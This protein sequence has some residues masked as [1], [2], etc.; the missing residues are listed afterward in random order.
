MK[1]NH[2]SFRDNKDFGDNNFRNTTPLEK[3]DAPVVKKRKLE[4]PK[5]KWTFEK[6]TMFYLIHFLLVPVSILVGGLLGYINLFLMALPY[7][8]TIILAFRFG[9]EMRAKGLDYVLWNLSVLVSTYTHQNARALR[10]RYET[11]GIASLVLMTLGSLLSGLLF[12]VGIVLLLLFLVFAFAE[13]D[14]EAIAKLGKWMS[15]A[16]LGAGV[17]AF[18]MNPMLAHGALVFSLVG[19]WLYEKW[20]DYTFKTN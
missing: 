1:M 9:G 11:I 12:G 5:R 19:N 6:E 16:L 3:G 8:F 4:V 18:F 17:I 2:E 7:I 10:E 13:Q 14:N 20:N 15:F